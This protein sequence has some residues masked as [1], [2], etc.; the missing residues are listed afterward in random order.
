MLNISMGWVHPAFT[1]REK[2]ATRRNWKQVHAEKFV[3]AFQNASPVEVLNKDRRAGG[4]QIG[5]IQLTQKPKIQN[6]I[7]MPDTDYEA[8]GFKFLHH[9]QHL[10]PNKH[11]IP[12]ASPFKTFSWE[13]FIEWKM[14]AQDLWIIRFK[15]LELTQ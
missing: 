4:K 15:I 12:K 10:I 6:T 5:I 9:N 3:R 7:F 8:E 14:S 1:A 13:E 2:G 11:L